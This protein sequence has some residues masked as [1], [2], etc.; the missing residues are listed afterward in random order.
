MGAKVLIIGLDGAT[1][2]VINP[3]IKAGRLPHLARLAEEG[4]AVPLQSTFPDC[5]A[6]AWTSCRTGVNPGKHGIFNFWRHVAYEWVLVTSLNLQVPAVE[7]ILSRQGYRVCIV[8]VPI[9]Y[10]PQPVN[11]F[12]ISGLPTPGLESCFTY[13]A[14]LYTKLLAR[15]GDYEVD[16]FGDLDMS[17]PNR[18]LRQ[19]YGRHRRRREVTRYL[20]ALEQWDYFMVVFTISDKI[21][22]GFWQARQRWKQ[23]D[24]SDMAQRYGP[25]I[26]QC[27][28]L[29]DET[30]GR[31]LADAGDEGSVIVLSDH[32][33]GPCLHEVY[34]N[35][36]LREQ[37]Y[38][39]LKFA[40]KFWARQI[41]WNRREKVILLPR[42]EV[43]PPRRRI[44]WGRTRAFG[45]LYVEPSSLRLNLKGRDPQ[46]TVTPGQEAERLLQ[47]LTDQLLTL[48]MPDDQPMF[49]KVYRPEE[50]YDGPCVSQA[51]DLF[52]ELQNPDS[53]LL[54]EFTVK[55]LVRPLGGMRTIS[56]NHRPLG[57]LFARGPKVEKHAL[58]DV[59][60]IMDI[61]PTVLQLLG[62]PLRTYMDGRPLFG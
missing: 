1:F 2:D 47:T 53:R 23:G 30:V 12:V 3:L 31:L 50:V 13:P 48:K 27:Y 10:P 58:P 25:V 22:H 5:S 33:F 32:G 39:R 28:E 55:E 52:L 43:G 36:W 16:G 14:G 7:H 34:P 57:I 46:G 35:V 17:T 26:D 20:F 54:G 29:L 41:H 15:V 49:S 4:V 42:V 18:L 51:A 24:T 21:Q 11:G 59:P 19:L 9:T 45:G 37:G 8:N 6:P 44:H 40:H 56:G 61:G 60:H 38:L 62:V